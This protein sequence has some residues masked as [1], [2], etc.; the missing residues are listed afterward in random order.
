MITTDVIC[1]HA[2]LM[3]EKV[4]INAPLYTNKSQIATTV[5]S[6]T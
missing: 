2:Q 3:L 6:K 1:E 4:K 5:R